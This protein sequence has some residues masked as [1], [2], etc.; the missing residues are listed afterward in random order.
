VAE[1]VAAQVVEVAEQ[2]APAATF[3][4]AHAEEIAE[5][6]SVEPTPEPVK[7]AEV[8]MVADVPPVTEGSVVVAAVPAPVEEVIAEDKR[9][10]NDAEVLAAL[11]SLT[12]G[13][14]DFSSPFAPQESIAPG[15]MNGQSGEASFTG[16]RWVAEAVA[17]AEEESTFLLPHEMEKAH[18]AFAAFEGG[19][20]MMAP[21]V[22]TLAPTNGSGNGAV[23]ESPDAPVQQ[24]QSNPEPALAP[25]S[26]SAPESVVAV[27]SETIEAANTESA[28]AAAASAGAGTTEPGVSDAQPV[29]SVETSDTS[30][31]SPEEGLVQ[32][33]SE[34]AAAWANW[35]QIRKSILGTE[36]LT[37]APE[38][39]PPAE[40]VQVPQEIHTP[41]EAHPAQEGS[42]APAVEIAQSENPEPA[43]ENEAAE[44]SSIV[45]NMLAELKPKLM[46]EI[47]KK[48]KK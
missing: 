13:G 34:L 28:Y 29:A 47:K 24:P 25:V 3:A 9:P 8:V 36:G 23:H 33:E 42:A 1:A 5:N 31:S 21:F 46:E 16:P 35:R 20:A 14:G 7:E 18:A 32:R 40:E 4:T 39:S 22:E 43:S 45:D 19:R 37:L 12:P 30:A 2:E 38:I 48:L 17:L 27:A 6:T 26:E 15:A 41:E 44:I 10:A 11:A